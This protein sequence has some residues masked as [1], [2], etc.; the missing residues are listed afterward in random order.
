MIKN[1]LL[2]PKLTYSNHFVNQCKYDTLLCQQVVYHWPTCGSS[3]FV[4]HGAY[5]VAAPGLEI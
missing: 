1:E 3:R 2:F 4:L 5:P